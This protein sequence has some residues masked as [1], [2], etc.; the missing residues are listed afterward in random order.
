LQLIS[1][2]VHGNISRIIQSAFNALY[3]NST[4]LEWIRVSGQPRRAGVDLSLNLFELAEAVHEDYE[5]I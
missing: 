3:K 5:L 1:D 2:V 4:K